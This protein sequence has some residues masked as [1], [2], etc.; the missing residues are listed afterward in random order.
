MCTSVGKGMFPRVA[1][2]RLVKCMILG[3]GL[4]GSASGSDHGDGIEGSRRKENRERKGG[5]EEGGMDW[6][7]RELESK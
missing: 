5:G 1:R 7:G 6:I 3:S 4:S 2:S